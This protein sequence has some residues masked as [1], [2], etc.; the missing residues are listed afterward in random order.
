M[1]KDGQSNS[2]QFNSST[3]KNDLLIEEEK[4]SMDHSNRLNES[5]VRKV[6]DLAS[7]MLEREERKSKEK[8]KLV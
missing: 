7:H 8:L 1:T 4:K 6:Q 3:A 2:I 5:R